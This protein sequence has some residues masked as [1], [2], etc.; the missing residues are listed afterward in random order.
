MAGVCGR[1]C[2]NCEFR[3]EYGCGGCLETEGRPVWGECRVVR[4]CHGK[5][6]A[7]CGECPSAETCAAAEQAGLQRERFPQEEAER[8]AREAER[9]EA[10][11]A[12]MARR[13]PVLAKWLRVLF[14]L[15]AVGSVTGLLG[16]LDLEGGVSLAVELLSLAVGVGGMVCYWKLS[17]L[18]DRF[19]SVWHWQMVSLGLA[20]LAIVVLLAVRDVG[21]LAFFGAVLGLAA[22][23][24][25]IVVIYQSC[26][27]MAEQLDGEEQELADNWRR[28]RKWTLWSLGAMVGCVL[29]A[30]LSAM[31]GMLVLVGVALV[32][33]GCAIA[34]LV[35]IC[36]SARF[37]REQAELAALPSA[38]E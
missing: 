22:A 33:V 7:H 15:S 21:T 31:L 26:E 32:L 11:R 2:G 17:A 38:R 16:E 24:I 25:S 5:G 6:L 30:L 12:E 8:R 3:R 29:L 27:A 37:F 19:R 23:A 14:W 35:L 13:A 18:S 34:E 20:A 10:R 4:C 36:Q 9:Q 28:L 1:D